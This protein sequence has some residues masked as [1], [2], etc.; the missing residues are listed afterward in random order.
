MG[1]FNL[2]IMFFFYCKFIF[3]ES[4]VI[5][6]NSEMIPELNLNLDINS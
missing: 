1:F 6:C 2:T 5:S 3:H 4:E